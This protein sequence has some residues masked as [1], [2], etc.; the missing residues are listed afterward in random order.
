MV[1]T[2]TSIPARYAVVFRCEHGKFI[3]DGSN[4]ESLYK[5]F[6]AGDHVTVRYREVFEVDADK[7]VLVDLDFLGAEPR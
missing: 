2:S 4:G 5:R 1:F 6:S 7:R 3:I